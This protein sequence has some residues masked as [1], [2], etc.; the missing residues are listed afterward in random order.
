[1]TPF[2]IYVWSALPRVSAHL[3]ISAGLLVFVSLPLGTI[4][5]DLADDGKQVPKWRWRSIH[6]LLL[7]GALSWAGTLCPD[8]SQVKKI[9]AGEK[10]D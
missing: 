6:C 9:L 2:E 5:A 10:N 4:V 1:M 8:E 3:Y 7:A